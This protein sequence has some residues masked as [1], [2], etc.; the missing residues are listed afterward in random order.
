MVLLGLIACAQ[1]H[2]DC[3]QD[4]KELAPKVQTIDDPGTRRR[5]EKYLV[6]A[7]R[8]L[9]EGDELDCQPAADAVRAFL[10]KARD[11]P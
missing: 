1:A 3:E 9:D 6:R 7:L 5:A 4:I 10:E 2:A 11:Q 8:E